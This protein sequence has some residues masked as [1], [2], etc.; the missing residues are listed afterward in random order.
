V[1]QFVSMNNAAY[2]TAKLTQT[3]MKLMGSSTIF[4][5]PHHSD[6]NGIAKRTIGKLKESIYKM[7]V[8]KQ[9]SWPK[10]LDLI[11]DVTIRLFSHRCGCRS[12]LPLRIAIQI[13][14]QVHVFDPDP[15][16]GPCISV[17]NFF[18]SDYSD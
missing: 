3:M 13:R 6:G 18:S 11:N 5:T 2:N 14:I 15:D 8:D 9:N 7:T 12:D 17:S 4:I 10:Y 1:S 16:P